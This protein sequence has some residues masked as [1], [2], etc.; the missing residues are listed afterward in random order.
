M[1]A[2]EAGEYKTQC[3][4]KNLTIQALIEKGYEVIFKRD[5]AIIKGKDFIIKGE[6]NENNLIKGKDFIIKGEINENNL[7]I[8]TVENESCNTAKKDMKSY[9][10]EIQ[11]SLRGKI[12]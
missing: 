7:A 2:K 11:Q 8:L 9:L 6:I 5:T 12:L 10:N 3:Q 4:G 1:T